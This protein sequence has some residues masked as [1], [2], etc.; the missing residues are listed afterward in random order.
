MRKVQVGIVK[1]N[2]KHKNDGKRESMTKFIVMELMK[3]TV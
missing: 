1:N 2:E 3:K